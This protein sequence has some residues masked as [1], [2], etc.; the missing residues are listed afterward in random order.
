MRKKTEK[1]DITL[2]FVC[3]DSFKEFITKFGWF[4]TDD[5]ICLMPH[6][7]CGEKR[8]RIN[9]CPSCGKEIRDIHLSEDEL[10]YLIS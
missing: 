7:K 6:I 1:Q 4:K 2:S 3:C 10:L 8:M 5:N 9:Y